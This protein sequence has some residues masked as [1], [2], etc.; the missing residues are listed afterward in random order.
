M[1]DEWNSS[2][3]VPVARL[4]IRQAKGV[5]NPLPMSGA[6]THLRPLPLRMFWYLL[7][8]IVKFISSPDLNEKMLRILTPRNGCAMVT[9]Q[10]SCRTVSTSVISAA[11]GHK[12]YSCCPFSY[13]CP[14]PSSLHTTTCR[15]CGWWAVVLVSRTSAILALQT[16]AT[17][18]TQRLRK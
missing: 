4:L 13:P 3:V 8:E 12:D 2:Q 6:L 14:E 18:S 9:C 1:H 16:R 15:I 17:G 11:I 10:P 7:D 5:R